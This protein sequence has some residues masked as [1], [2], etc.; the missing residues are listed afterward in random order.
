MNNINIIVI[1]SFFVLQSC[2]REVKKEYYPDGTLRTEYEIVKGKKNG[3][4][5]SYYPNG[6]YN[7]IA[8]YKEDS[9]HGV[10]TS[11]YEDGT[12]HWELN[13]TY[14]KEHGLFKKIDERGY[15]WEEEFKNGLK[16]G[17]SKI[18]YPNGRIRSLAFYKNNKIEGE[19][20]Y[21]YENG[22]LEQVGYALHDSVICYN[23]YKENGELDSFKASLQIRPQ[24]D[25]IALGETYKAKILVHMTL[26]KDNKYYIAVS[27][28]DT[29]P[30]ESYTEYFEKDRI[31]NFEYK[32]TK[33]GKYYII[34]V[35]HWVA[36]HGVSEIEKVDSFI[37][38]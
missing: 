14:G 13:Y 6:N 23:T 11:Y 30:Q 33:K 7:F 21:F 12:I 4:Y 31:I 5:K 29:F 35:G 20:K 18:F 28:S 19:F 38:K 36:K 1:I 2:T 8:Y 10:K 16:S 9:L 3:Y 22:E 17:Y 24:K 34:A 15:K 26:E 32:P 37:V 25:T 27:N